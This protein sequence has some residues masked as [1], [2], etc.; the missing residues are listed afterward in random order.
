MLGD[1]GFRTLDLDDQQRL[2]I[3]G[4]PGMG[5]VF[6]G[7]DCRLVHELHGDRQNARLDDIGHTGTRHL[8]GIETKQDGSRPLG[9]GQDFQNSLGNHAELAFR[10]ANDAQEIKARRIEMG[11]AHLNNLAVHHHHGH[12]EKIVGRHAVFQAM[13]TARIHGDVAG[14]GTG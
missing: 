3:G 11:T 10:T 5:K 4:V 7:D 12:A 6:A 13:G 9:L 1:L 2:H 8:I 14:N